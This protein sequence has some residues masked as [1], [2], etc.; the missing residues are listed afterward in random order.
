MKK[1]QG[2]SQ[3]KISDL[4]NFVGS[5]EQGK[6]PIRVEQYQDMDTGEIVKIEIY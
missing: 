1:K 6:K 5:K 4:K 2:K 3:T